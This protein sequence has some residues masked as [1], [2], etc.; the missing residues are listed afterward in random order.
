MAE[1]FR[2]RG[3][4]DAEARGFHR[5]VDG[6]LRKFG[7]LRKAHVETTG[8]SR[9]LEAQTRA[10]NR[11]LERQSR[12]LSVLTLQFTALRNAMRTMAIRTAITG[13]A[14]LTSTVGAL[15]AGLIE[16][17][18]Q[19][20]LLSI[21]MGTVGVSAL[22]AFGQAAVVAGLALKG[23]GKAL[24]TTGTD[25]EKAMAKLTKPARDFVHELMGVQKAFREI[26]LVAQEGLFPGLTR[27]VKAAKPAL[28]EFKQVVW[29]TSRAMGYLGE[30]LGDLVGRRQKDLEKLGERNVVNIRRF[31]TAGLNATEAIM[32]VFR[33]A[34]PFIGHVTRG[35]VTLSEKLK[36]AAAKARADGSLGHFFFELKQTWDTWT[37]TFGNVAGSLLHIFTAASGPAKEVATA[38]KETTQKWEDWTGSTSGQNKLKEFFKSS[39]KVLG[40]M[41]KFAGAIFESLA[42]LSIEGGD[43]AIK[44]F[45][46]LRTTLLPFLEDLAT[47]LNR[48]LFTHLMKLGGSLTRFAH[49]ALPGLKPISDAIGFLAGKLAELLDAVGP[50][51]A[52]LPDVAKI[53]AALAIGAGVLGAWTKVK[54]MIV[55]ALL[56]MRQFFGLARET[57]VW[58]PG[59]R[60]IF[61]RGG[62]IDQQPTGFYPVG[63]GGQRPPLAGGAP[64]STGPHA[65]GMGFEGIRP[66]IGPYVRPPVTF[67]AAT[68]NRLVRDARDEGTLSGIRQIFTSRTPA[69]RTGLPMHGPTSRPYGAAADPRQWIGSQGQYT[70]QAGPGSYPGPAYAFRG[71][72]RVPAVQMQRIETGRTRAPYDLSPSTVR[73]GGERTAA[74][75]EF[76][77]IDRTQRGTFTKLTE[78][79]GGATNAG[80]RKGATL[81][82]PTLGFVFGAAAINGLISGLSSNADNWR[83]RVQDAVSGATFGIV[84][85]TEEKMGGKAAAVGRGIQAG[86]IAPVQIKNPN[87]ADLRY[88]DLTTPEGR[89]HTKEFIQQLKDSKDIS[90]EASDQ[91]NAMVDGYASRVDKLGPEAA[92]LPDAIKSGLD[93]GGASAKVVTDVDNINKAFADMKG[94]AGKNADEM[95][96]HVRTNMAA[97]RGSLDKDSES[98]RL[99]LAKNFRLAAA[100]VKSSMKSGEIGT[101]EG[102]AL[103]RGYLIDALQEV[104]PQWNRKQ[105]GLYLHNKDPTTG[106]P[107]S[108]T[109]QKIPQGAATGL[110]HHIPGAPGP[111]SVP[112]D[113]G[114]SKIVVAP[115]E[116]VAVFTRHQRKA[117]DRRL[118]DVGG[119]PGFFQSVPNKHTKSYAVGGLV[120]GG[121]LVTGDTDY[122]PGWPR[123]SRRWRA[124]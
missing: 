103:I 78:G 52:K 36:D 104:N 1:D 90:K 94:S 85:G 29:D 55:L 108:G 20:G 53:P 61:T 68:V 88:G 7:D 106:K 98:G 56:R 117:L 10:L 79:I 63:G 45:D 81:A 96:A 30:K 84:P 99:A 6:V 59:M 58:G 82:K 48:G 31:G 46:G 18:Q 74:Y 111:D 54:D 91:L 87:A 39:N 50:L 120:K 95:R 24:T 37:A 100:A 57:P 32:D 41:A 107:L 34:D 71:G 115:G 33:A 12:Q 83:G 23:V 49:D 76:Q 27:G 114:G 110:L 69:P 119:L 44:F 122:G 118:S 123:R 17:T 113:V 22:A 9:L 64:Y 14:S 102:T 43:N 19:A 65:A 4:I 40:S 62:K 28:D 109:R 72:L 35:I 77:N 93:L 86:N 2:I 42:R 112:M 101:K 97:I 11:E 26:K 8:T 92:K 15:G 121:G 25:H 21:G 73:A 38:I 67:T 66:A 70:Y 60:Q 3:V 80:I 75:R 47:Q 105:A 13:F 116:D 124:R 51:V 5:A 16:V 89:Q